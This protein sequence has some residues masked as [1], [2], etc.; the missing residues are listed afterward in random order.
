VSV[1]YKD[2]EIRDHVKDST[3]KKPGLSAEDKRDLNFIVSQAMKAQTLPDFLK[4]LRED[5]K[6]KDESPQ[7][8]ACAK[9]WR[10]THRS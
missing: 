4:I 5:L 9:W 1:L 6:L 7:F 8:R 3:R 10:E 2:Q